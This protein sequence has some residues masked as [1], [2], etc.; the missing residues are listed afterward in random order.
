MQSNQREE[1]HIVRPVQFGALEAARVDAQADSNNGQNRKDDADNCDC[2][3]LRWKHDLE[4]YT[5]VR[6]G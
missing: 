2:H 3:C 4:Q 5:S 1:D 6:V